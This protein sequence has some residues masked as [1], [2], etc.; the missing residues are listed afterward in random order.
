VN[1]N[2]DVIQGVSRNNFFSF[3]NNDKD[4]KMQRKLSVKKY[5]SELPKHSAT[6][7]LGKSSKYPIKT[8]IKSMKPSFLPGNGLRTKDLYN[9]IQS[10]KS[11]ANGKRTTASRQASKQINH[12][13]TDNQLGTQI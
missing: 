11:N 6:S 7:S 12:T 13:T 2:K 4:A 5:I 3:D 9:K 10:M 8:V 1:T